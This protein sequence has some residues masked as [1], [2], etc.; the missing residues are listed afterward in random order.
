MNNEMNQGTWAENSS[1]ASPA[2]T[3]NIWRQDTAEGQ[4]AAG[5]PQRGETAETK[6]FKENYGFFAP[7]VF[8]YAVFYVFC[9]YKNDSGI[10][11]PFFVGGGLL[12]LCL[13]LPKLGLTLKRGSVFY[14]AASALLG[15]STFCTDD[16]R[17]ISFNKLG[18]FLLIMSLLLKQFYDISQ[19]KL[20]KL[21]G[22]IAVTTIA[23]LGELGRPLSDGKQYRKEHPSKNSRQLWAVAAGFLITVPLFF[24]VLKLL[25][26]AD[27][28]F[29]KVTESLLKNIS[30]GD[31]ITV[32]FNIIVFFFA[33]YMLIS[34]LC[35]KTLK[36]EVKDRR[37]GEPV[38]AIMVTGL[39]TLLYL[40]FSGIQIAGL[41]LR[42]LELPE[43]YT[44]AMYA[45]EGFFQLLAVGL[46]NLVIV[47]VC[48]GFFRESKVL[49]AILTVMSLCTF[50]MIASSAMRMVIYIYYYYMTFLRLLVLW[51][52]VVLA[53][54]FAGIMVNIFKG[55]FPL[56]RYSLVVVTVLYLLLSFARPDYIIARVNIANISRENVE[57]EQ[58]ADGSGYA[59]R[60]GYKDYYYLGWLCADAAPVLVPYLQEHGYHMEAYQ[61]DPVQYLKDNIAD[62][63]AD[64]LRQDGF[65]YYWM[66]ERKESFQGLN[67]RTFNLSRYMAMKM[68]DAAAQQSL[69]QE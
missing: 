2:G 11:Y 32:F 51:G 26:E 40:L 35:R 54:L 55:N 53:L 39:L 45:R 36:E 57:S 58:P 41:F 44:Y 5:Q 8:I 59:D 48:I 21:M 10:T 30:F 42:Q 25:S 4:R 23:C 7:A 6:R 20:G 15:I 50:V 56:F 65:G 47:L 68:L 63:P 69:L 43:G 22:S 52:L 27:A 12:F 60:R 14:M 33:V 37:T 18:I 62:I 38:M 31:T 46:I 9:M 17:I 24:L 28:V 19:W 29:R 67:L 1:P 66:R 61:D 13:S 64:R 49:K 3:E 34:F 16:A